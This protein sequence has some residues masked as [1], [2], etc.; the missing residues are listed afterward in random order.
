VRVLRIYNYPG[1]YRASGGAPLLL[2]E[3]NIKPFK[4][5]ENN[6]FIAKCPADE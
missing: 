6:T 1:Y 3:D 5:I 2:T 4:I